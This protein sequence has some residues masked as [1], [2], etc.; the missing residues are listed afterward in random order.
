[1]MV[2]VVVV[3]LLLVMVVMVVVE[4]GWSVA[5]LVGQLVPRV[6]PK[7]KAAAKKKTKTVLKDGKRLKVLEL[8]KTMAKAKAKAG[9]TSGEAVAAPEDRFDLV[10]EAWKRAWL[11]GEFLA[12]KTMPRSGEGGPEAWSAE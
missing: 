7:G 6:Y 12:F 10:P 11:C 3:L 1:M 4:T 5:Q 2:V 9:A 8:K